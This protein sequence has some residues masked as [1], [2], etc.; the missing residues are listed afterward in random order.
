MGVE[1]GRGGA[2]EETCLRKQW[3]LEVTDT[4]CMGTE[5]TDKFYS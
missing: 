2:C 1:L 3:G 4:H 5:E